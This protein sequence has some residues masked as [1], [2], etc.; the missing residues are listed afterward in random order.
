MRSKDLPSGGAGPLSSCP[1]FTFTAASLWNWTFTEL[2][3]FYWTGLTLRVFRKIQCEIFSWKGERFVLIFSVPRNLEWRGNSCS[4]LSY[5]HLGET[6]SSREECWWNGLDLEGDGR[7]WD[8]LRLLFC[9]FR[10]VCGSSHF[11]NSNHLPL[12]YLFQK[13]EGPQQACEN[14]VTEIDS[15]G[16]DQSQCVQEGK[17]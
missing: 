2:S 16:P 14:R 13:A 4:D 7:L 1:R 8:V 5:R 10:G 17:H 3:E 9:D 15:H 12:F 11:T 6:D